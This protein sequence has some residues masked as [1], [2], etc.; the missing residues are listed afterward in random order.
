ML[1]IDAYFDSTKITAYADNNTNQH[2][3]SINDDRNVEILKIFD[4]KTTVQE[5]G[6]EDLI[7]LTENKNPLGSE[8]LSIYIYII[9]LFIIYSYIL[10]I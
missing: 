1:N 2:Y 7:R 3:I 10:Y 6:D 9:I 5:S 4:T 8:L